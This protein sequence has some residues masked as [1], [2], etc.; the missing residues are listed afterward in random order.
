MRSAS[1]R[2]S[3]RDALAGISSSAVSSEVSMEGSTPNRQ[4]VSDRVV[5][6]LPTK[7]ADAEEEDSLRP[8]PPRRMGRVA[9]F[10]V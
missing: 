1:G 9:C 7:A 5:F 10:Q 2:T 3:F 4:A 6:W 8:R